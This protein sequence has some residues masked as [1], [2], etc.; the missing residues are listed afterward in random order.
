MLRR[1]GS[2]HVVC[3]AALAAAA[4][5]RPP[6]PDAYGNVEATSVV[7]AAEVGGRVTSIAADD[8]VTLAAGTIV[9]T[10]DSTELGL[11]Q[12]HLDL[13]RA[14]TASRTRELAEQS[15]ALEAQRAALLAERGALESQRD[16]AQRAY[17]RTKRLVADQAATAQQL[18]QAERDLRVLVDQLRAKDEQIAAEG[19]QI[20][21]VHAQQRTVAGQVDAAEA[22]VALA[23]ER[24]RRASVR[25]PIAGTV[26]VAYARTGEFVQAGQPLYKIADLSAVDVRAFITEP[27]LA[28]TKLGQ[29]AKVSHD[30]GQTIP[31]TV[32]WIASEAE[33]TP[34][35]IQTRDER[36][37]LVYAVKIRVPNPNG[38]LKIGMPVD[39]RFG[40]AP[41]NR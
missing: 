22:Q 19:R 27:Q 20:A 9:A 28:G 1:S 17:D 36:A 3:T 7:V 41:A 13:Q 38:V 23:A 18:D 34:T 16:I 25:N 2:L 5:A 15:G 39:V 32:T 40:E 6:Q 31:G 26:L 14:A 30:P 29:A 10:I 35:P 33:F 24:I 4:C 8:G 37:D 11:E 21:T 12:Q